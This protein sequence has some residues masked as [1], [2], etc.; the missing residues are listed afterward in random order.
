MHF[1]SLTLRQFRNYEA[2]TLRPSS[3]ITVLYGANG[4]GKTNVLEAMHLLSL[5]RS[6]RTGADKEMVGE[7]QAVACV[8]GETLRLDGKHDMEV[9][10]YP[11]EKPHKRV[12][13]FGKPAQRIGDMMGHATCVMFAPEDIRIVRD[14]PAARRRFVDMQLSQIRPAYLK[15]LKTYLTVL[16]SRNALLKAQRLAPMADFNTQLETWDEQ[17]AR[18]A[19]QVAQHRRWFLAEL[20]REAAAQYAAIAEDPT[21][22]F[23][24]RYTGPLATAQQPYETM[25][26]GLK[27]TRGEDM[28]RQYT[29]YG[30]HRDDVAML[31]CGK[32]LR[33]FGSQGQLRTAVLSMKLG[34]LSLIQNEMG[35]YPALLLDDVFSEL[36]VK[37]R[38]A[39]LKSTEGV[40]TFLTCTDKQDAAGA[41]ADIFLRVQQ[42]EA[43]HAF[44]EEA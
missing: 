38:S 35:E 41:Q 32:E 12:L 13:L 23:E 10:L 5:G 39:L 42:D 31:L 28:H 17:L 19:V 40:Q 22:T 26:T 4:S 30:P 29:S 9:R 27:R 1:T 21:E 25:L 11:L 2:L 20:S 37:R 34:E 44:I 16:E 15:G 14:G 33:A 43:G 8:Q 3:G 24:L 18:A 7:G 36:D 6:H